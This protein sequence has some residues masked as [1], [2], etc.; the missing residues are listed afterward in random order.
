MAAGSGNENVGS[1]DRVR[2]VVVLVPSWADWMSIQRHAVFSGFYRGRAVFFLFTRRMNNLSYE[3]NIMYG[4][5]YEVIKN[6]NIHQK[7]TNGVCQCQVV[8]S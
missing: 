2:G 6:K 4:Y 8:L 7:I 3:H 5:A 1:I